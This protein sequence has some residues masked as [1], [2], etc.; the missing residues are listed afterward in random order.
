[1]ERRSPGEH[2]DDDLIGREA[3]ILRL[4]SLLAQAD[5]G[6]GGLVEI[7]GERGIGKSTLAAKAGRSAMARGFRVVQGR[8][9]TEAPAWLAVAPC[10]S[11]LG[12][13]LPPAGESESTFAFFGDVLASLA[14]SAV[15]RPQLWIIEDV[16]AAD[17]ATLDL[18][19]FLAAPLRTLR[20]LVIV[21]TRTDALQRR[22]PALDQRIGRLRALG[23]E[24]LLGP[25]ADDNVARIAAHVLGRTLNHLE[26]DELTRRAGGK[27]L[28]VVECMRG[29]ALGQRLIS[30]TVHEIVRARLVHLGTPTRELL[31]AA[32]ILGGEP[33]VG[34]LAAMMG[35]LPATVID[36]LE[37]A[38][39][40]GVPLEVE[41]GKF[42]F[43]HVGSGN[44]GRSFPEIMAAADA[45][46]SGPSK[47]FGLT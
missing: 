30:R 47:S 46:A 19:G 4:E 29:T 36:R 42:R 35:E 27:P 6:R 7:T 40:H 16:H 22:D 34:V 18:L 1:M 12:L 2:S 28:F 21:T 45:T 31:R 44:S 43:T 9:W 20:A 3:E 25:L 24:L 33:T 8:A 10:I 26:R 15:E 17:A 14:A 32:A 37:P 38:R 41:P 5:Q 11:S 39:R 13:A 23:S